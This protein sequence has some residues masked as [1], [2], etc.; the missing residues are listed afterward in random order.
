MPTARPFAYHTGSQIA[1]TEKYGN[2]SVGVT[3]QNYNGG[4][5]G[6]TWYNGA[7][8]DPGYVIAYA[9]EA[10]LEPGFRRTDVKTESAFLALVNSLPPRI[11]QTPFVDGASAVTWLNANGFWT[12]FAPYPSNL[13]VYLDSGILPSYPGSG[14]NWFDLTN[15]DNHATLI[16][17]PTYS[18]S[19]NGILQFDDTS[20]E[21]AAI[22]NI[23]D[24]SQWTVEAW[25][26]LTT[27]LSG[28][29]TSVISN[30]FNLSNKLNFSIG[31]NNA[32][33]NY[34]LAVGFYDGAWRSTSG[35]TPSLNT[36]YQVVGTYDG[37]TVRQYVNGSANGGTLTYSGTPQSGGE[38]RLMRRWDSTLLP[39]NLLD[40]DLAIIKVYNTA[41]NSGEVLSNFNANKDRFGL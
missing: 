4:Y 15:Y 3:P 7:D 21:Y 2:L 29:V 24:I 38:V 1:G 20:Y 39:G 34:N 13:L 40:G 25:F 11:G 32:P 23:G 28:K 31:T 41:L 16:N 37:T 18:V 27:S 30:Q 35:F 19:N 22:P 26:R 33:V 36:W 12:S 10:L 6:V 14:S 5:G 9:R 17:S 8:E